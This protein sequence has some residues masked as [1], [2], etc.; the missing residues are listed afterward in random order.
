M[1]GSER[2]GR[3]GRLLALVIVVSLAVLLVLAKFRFRVRWPPPTPT[4]PL[5]RIVARS[6]YEDMAATI[7]NLVQ[8]LSPSVVVLVATPIPPD[9]KPSRGQE[10]RRRAGHRCCRRD[11]WPA[12]RVGAG[13]GGR[14]CACRLSGHRRPGARRGRSKSSAVDAD[15]SH[16]RRS[17]DVGVRDGERHGRRDRRVRGVQLCRGRRSGGG[18]DD[19]LAGVRRAGRLD[20]T[21]RQWPT[22][23]RVLGWHRRPCRSAR[24]SSRWMA[25]SSAWRPRAPDGVRLL[26][27]AAAIDATVLTLT[28]GGKGSRP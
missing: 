2:T 16:R 9:A 18:W 1:N 26:I 8:R 7:A 28:S 27:P 24:W 23:V 22:P 10:G 6:T 15:R 4:G 25:G 19:R 20:R 21:T 5:E 3:D 12:I 14:P 11:S 17:R 13:S